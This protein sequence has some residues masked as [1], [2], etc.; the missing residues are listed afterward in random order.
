MVFSHRIFIEDD[1]ENLNLTTKKHICF[2]SLNSN[3]SPLLLLLDSSHGLTFILP[4]S[5]TPYSTS[6]NHIEL[7]HI[8]IGYNMQLLQCNDWCKSLFDVLKQTNLINFP[9]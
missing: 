6:A 4:N 7:I 9:W 8:E 2:I 3:F 5:P 1:I